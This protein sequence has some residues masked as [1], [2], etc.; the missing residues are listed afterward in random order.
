M[1]LTSGADNHPDQAGTPYETIQSETQAVTLTSVT[2]GHFTLTFNGQTTASLLWN[3][4]ASDVANALDGLS[5]IGGVGGSVTVKRTGTVY[6]VTFDGG[7]L[8]Q[9]NVAQLSATLG[10]DASPGGGVSVQ[11]TVDGGFSHPTGI[12]LTFDAT[13]WY[14][15]QTVY[16]VVDNH[17]EQI[18][19]NLDF[20]NSA[21]VNNAGIIKGTVSTAV[22][23]DQDPTTVGDE[24][25]R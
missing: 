9:T 5:N 3:A 10:G 7:T 2:G 23:V 15:P 25:R 17:A 18:G 8:A 20:Q 14:L 13:N 6:A 19:S 24:Y 22:S 4:S 1:L 12:A 21:A 11:S 16:F